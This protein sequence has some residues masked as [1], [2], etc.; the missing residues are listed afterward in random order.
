MGR[1]K[2]SKQKNLACM[3]LHVYMHYK[4]H[5]PALKTNAAQ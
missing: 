4:I 3:C 1:H 2:V 5:I